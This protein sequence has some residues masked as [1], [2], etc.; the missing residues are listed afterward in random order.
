MTEQPASRNVTPGEDVLERAVRARLD[1]LDAGNYRANN[2]LI[3]SSFATFLREERDVTDPAEIEVIDCR[4]YAQWLRSR[5]ANEE[6]SL[7]AASAHANGPYFTIVRAFLAW[8]VDDERIDANP[9]RPK[10]VRDALPEYRG[11]PDRQFWPPEAK[12]ALLS[13]VDERVRDELDGR[14]LSSRGDAATVR[15][16]LDVATFR[17]RAVVVVLAFTGVRGAEV[18]SDPRDDNREGLRWADVD[19]GR[20]VASVLGKI[21]ERQAVALTDDVIRAL[22]QYRRVL[23]PASDSW[24]VFPT[25]HRPSLARAARRGLTERGWTESEI[26]SAL[27][28]SHTMAVLGQHDVAPPALSKNGARNLMKRLCDEAG[29]DV[30]GEYLKP[31]GGRRALGD[32]LYAADAEL[33][34][35]T[36]RHESIET[37]HDAYREQ[38]AIER[39]DRIQD[40]LE[41]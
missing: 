39:R 29:V 17:D 22:Q 1:A 15:D 3:L 16:D 35:E 20:G 28:D 34:Q 21:R 12:D 5:V 23:A 13:F 18:F 4:R 19:L 36:L 7:S 11:G 27:D 9:A 38:S 2:D 24:P 41:E 14:G 32:Q 33:A 37:T 26:D 40:V 6:D 10:R 31:H 8:C 30:D 25:R